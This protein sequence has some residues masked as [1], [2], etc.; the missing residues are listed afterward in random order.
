MNLILNK[1]PFND[2]CLY[3]GGPTPS[4]A[5]VRSSAAP[6]QKTESQV[7]Q[8]RRDNG[9]ANARRKGF[10]ASILAGETGGYKKP[11]LGKS[12]S[13]AEP[14]KATTTLLGGGA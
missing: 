2:P 4:Y 9:R 1:R 13:N 6:P 5:P 12:S 8:A 10:Q 14:V 3:K 11:V 7:V